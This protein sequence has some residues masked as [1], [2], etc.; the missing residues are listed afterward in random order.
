MPIATIVST[1]AVGRA[2]IYR[3][4]E[5]VLKP[6]AM[7]PRPVRATVRART[8]GGGAA[9]LEVDVIARAKGYLCVRRA[10]EGAAPW[11]AWVPAEA[12][13]VGLMG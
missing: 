5:L 13:D 8:F 2:S 6:Q 7:L 4:T 12:V 3:Y 10:R 11:H 1:L 9:T